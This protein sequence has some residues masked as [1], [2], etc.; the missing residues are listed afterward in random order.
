MG[1]STGT[2]DEMKNAEGI[3][4]WLNWHSPT[5]YDLANTKE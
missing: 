2:F 3:P 4:S 5:Q 1:V